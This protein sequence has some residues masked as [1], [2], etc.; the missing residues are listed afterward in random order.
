MGR[1]KNKNSRNTEVTQGGQR[2]GTTQVSSIP[3][4]AG[5]IVVSSR[6]LQSFIP[7]PVN[8]FDSNQLNRSGK[9]NPDST[10][11]SSLYST[12]PLLDSHIQVADNPAMSVVSSLARSSA[13]RI[14]NTPEYLPKLHTFVPEEGI[15]RKQGYVLQKL[16]EE[17]LNGKRRC[18]GCGKCE[19][20]LEFR[21]SSAK[22]L[23]AMS[24]LASKRATRVRSCSTIVL[25]C[26]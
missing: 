9:R 19:H 13:E 25:H 4:G 23:V 16:S 17:E 6:P 26:P 3:S 24:K 1:K 12:N 2:A 18:K 21:T 10:S 8:S 14:E 7:P 20:H 22:A 11:V 15:L 5:A